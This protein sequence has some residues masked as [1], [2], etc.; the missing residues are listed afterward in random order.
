MLIFLCFIP[1]FYDG[2]FSLID[3]LILD[4]T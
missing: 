2:L 1:V 4:A 3:F